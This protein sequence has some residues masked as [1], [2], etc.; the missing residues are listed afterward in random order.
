MSIILNTSDLTGL[1]HLSDSTGLRHLSDSTGLRHLSDS[2][3]LRHLSDSTGL[4]GSRYLSDSTGIRR[5]EFELSDESCIFDSDCN[6]H[7]IC[8]RG[9]CIKRPSDH[10]FSHIVSSPYIVSPL[11]TVT[12]TIA[13][14]TINV[15]QEYTYLIKFSVILILLCVVAYC[16][17]LTVDRDDRDDD[18]DD[19]DD[20]TSSIYD[21]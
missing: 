20:V 17:T 6:I 8:L 10:K 5:L 14:Y 1:R 15:F 7:Y 18:D 4:T 9:D 12:P 11:P 19:D 21:V 16:C 3:G 13:P 2:T